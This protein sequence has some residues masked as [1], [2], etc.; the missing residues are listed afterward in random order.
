MGRV[1]SFPSGDLKNKGIPVR[2]DAKQPTVLFPRGSVVI[3]N[4]GSPPMIVCGY[5][6]KGKVVVVFYSK[7]YGCITEEKFAPE[8]LIQITSD[9]ITQ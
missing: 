8:S 1:I 3:L 9:F 6:R 5:S 2:E 4:T 7:E